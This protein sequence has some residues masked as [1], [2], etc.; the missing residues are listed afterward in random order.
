M[1]MKFGVLLTVL[2]LA[3][4]F[5]IFVQQCRGGEAAEGSVKTSDRS[6]GPEDQEGVSVT[7]YNS[8]LGLVKDVRRIDLPKGP[9]ALKFMEVAAQILPQTVHIRSLDRPDDLDVLEQNYEFDLLT[10]Q[11]LLDKFVGKEIKVLKEG[12]E[13][14][15]TILSTNSGL[16]YRMGERIFT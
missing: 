12:A 4:G 5:L 6:S 16:V 15:I 7:V 11:K 10:P 2:F 1:K 13:V 9:T 14:P 8:N 3:C